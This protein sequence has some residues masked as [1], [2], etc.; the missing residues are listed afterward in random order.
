MPSMPLNQMETF[1]K[2]AFCFVFIILLAVP[3]NPEPD[4]FTPES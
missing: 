4:F 3:P 1:V 2:F